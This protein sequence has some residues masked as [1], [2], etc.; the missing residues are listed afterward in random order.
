MINK[1]IEAESRRWLTGSLGS[2]GMRVTPLMVW[3]LFEGDEMIW[4]Q[5]VVTV[6]KHYKYI[7]C[8]SIICF[9]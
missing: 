2:G 8:H 9:K 3:G 7:K 6:G 4:S 5:E 1:Y